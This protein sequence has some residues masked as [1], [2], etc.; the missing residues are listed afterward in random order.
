MQKGRF[1]RLLVDLLC[2]VTK[3]QVPGIICLL[4]V[5]H[6]LIRLA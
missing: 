4:Q 6:Y 3:V 2:D 1:L 5:L